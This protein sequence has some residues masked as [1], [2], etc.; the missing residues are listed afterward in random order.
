MQVLRM[1]VEEA[2]VNLKDLLNELAEGKQ[3]VLMENDQE[4]ARLIPSTNRVGMIENTRVF[5]RSL[6]MS[7]ESLSSTIIREREEERG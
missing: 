4:I 6:Q 2:L 7:G 3:V 1:T 5:R